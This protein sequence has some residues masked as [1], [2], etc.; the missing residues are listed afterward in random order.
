M[1]VDLL[2]RGQNR[3]GGWPYV[4][5]AS[6]TEPTVYGVL[7]L[8]DAGEQDAA[9]RGLRWLQ[10]AQRRDGGWPPQLSVDQST[11]ATALVALLPP[12]RLGHAAHGRAVHW[13]GGLTGEES[14]VTYRFR[15]W[16]LGHRTPAEEQFP[17]WP[18]IPGAAAW[19]SPTSLTILALEKV[20]RR[21]PSVELASRIG[22]G[23]RFL[24]ERVCADGGWNH[25]STAALGYA[26]R[27]YPETTGMALT[28]LRGVRSPKIDASL[29]TAHG[30]LN[31]CRSADAWNWLRLGLL[32]HKQLS[33]TDAAPGRFELRTVQDIAMDL[34]VNAAIEGR[35]VFRA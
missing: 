16:L 25:G 13:L 17:G 24:L 34:L 15:E 14:T 12:E 28:A 20:C 1:H 9:V 35:D 8:L 3:D 32:A 23:K 19:V 18:W 7:A 27:S 5:G 29:A 2:L 33:K 31:E 26:S 4:R 10:S 22:M 11:W 21:E 30:F 6:W